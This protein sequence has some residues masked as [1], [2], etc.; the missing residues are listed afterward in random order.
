MY[1]GFFIIVAQNFV[2][3]PETR[4]EVTARSRNELSDKQKKLDMFKLRTNLCA[5]ASTWEE[6]HKFALKICIEEKRGAVTS[7]AEIRDCCKFFEFF[8][9]LCGERCKFLSEHQLHLL[10]EISG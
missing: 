9:L 10:R 2:M 3:T 7:L 5:P 6:V 4:R 1:N 8:P